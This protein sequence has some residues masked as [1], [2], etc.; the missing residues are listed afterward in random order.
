MITMQSMNKDWGFY[1]SMRYHGNPDEA[2]P[3]A[4]QAIMRASGFSE[5]AVRDF[6]D[7]R[8]GRHFADD[9][10]NTLHDGLS[11]PTAIDAA[12]ER[13]MAWTVHSYMQARTGIP[14][15]LPYLVGLVGEQEIEGE[16]V[17]DL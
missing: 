15:G 5:S 7:S 9:V 16:I 3:L 14:Q 10:A 1:G 8:H 13:W 17:S 12:V 4:M 11:L 2:W 6:L